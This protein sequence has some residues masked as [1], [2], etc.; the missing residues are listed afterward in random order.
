MVID[1]VVSENAAT[2]F[3]NKV[4]EDNDI[5]YL[6]CEKLNLELNKVTL[7]LTSAKEIIE[8]WKEELGISDKTVNE[9]GR[10]SYN[11]NRGILSTSN[12][13]LNQIKGHQK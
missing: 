4:I 7:E 13:T 8:I 2:D 12:E 11:F 5:G 9:E 6:Y 10:I 3:M 1:A